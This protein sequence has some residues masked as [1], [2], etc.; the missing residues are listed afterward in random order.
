MCVDRHLAG[1]GGEEGEGDA[2]G[3]A[4]CMHQAIW[5]PADGM[6]S[7]PVVLGDRESTCSAQRPVLQGCR[8]CRAVTATKRHSLVLR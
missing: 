6:F 4:A 5:A 3:P 1:E 7:P 2:A 8:G